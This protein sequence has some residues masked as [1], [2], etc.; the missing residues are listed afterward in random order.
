MTV[1]DLVVEATS[2][3]NVA[4]FVETHHYSK[5]VKGITPEFCFCVRYQ[6]EIIGAAIFGPPGMKNARLKYSEGGSVRLTELRRFVLIDDTPRNS[7]SRVL[8]L[9]FRDL[10]KQGVQ[11]ILSYAD[12]SH[13]HVGTIYRATGFQFIGQGTR[14]RVLWY[15]NQKISTRNLTR[16]V[17][18]RSCDLRPDAKRFRAALESGEATLEYEAGKFIYLKELKVPASA[19]PSTAAPGGIS[20]RTRSTIMDPESLT[21]AET[22]QRQAPAQNACFARFQ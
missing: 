16:C 9:M 11:R 3:E 17:R 8:G 10:A 20:G 21:F 6:T 22:E 7:E 2:I 15:R 13:G 4:E 14:T 18:D 19:S 12:P 1:H 5:S